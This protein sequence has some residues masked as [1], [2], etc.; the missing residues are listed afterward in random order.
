[1]KLRWR[2]IGRIK[3]KKASPD[4]FIELYEM[5]WNNIIETK[6]N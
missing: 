3:Y 4:T 6:L 1:M 5:K 2:R